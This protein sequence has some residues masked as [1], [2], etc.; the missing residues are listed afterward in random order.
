M[1]IEPPYGGEGERQ[2]DIFGDKVLEVL[3]IEL[4][5]NPNLYLVLNQTLY[6]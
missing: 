3:N 5:L 6:L 2:A 4:E 1:E